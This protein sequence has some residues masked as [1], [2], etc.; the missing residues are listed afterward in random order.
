[1]QTPPPPGFTDIQCDLILELRRDNDEQK[2]QKELMEKKLDWILDS[3]SEDPQQRRGP[4][5]LL[6]SV[7]TPK[8]PKSSRHAFPSSY[9][10]K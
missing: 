6:Q 4:E 10:S 3:G 1:V 8:W 5:N 9:H 2:F 7:M